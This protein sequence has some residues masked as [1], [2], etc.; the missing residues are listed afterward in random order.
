M[1]P[2]GGTVGPNTSVSP[3]PAAAERDCSDT[4]LDDAVKR[5]GFQGEPPEPFGT[6]LHVQG[7]FGARPLATKEPLWAAWRQQRWK[8]SRR[9]IGG[10]EG[11]VE[12]RMGG[13]KGKETG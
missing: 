13:R 2:L 7:G 9:E 11:S 5:Q 6:G 1:H 8:R 4:L 3:A 12:S 10:I